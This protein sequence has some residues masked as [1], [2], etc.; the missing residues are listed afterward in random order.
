MATDVCGMHS[1]AG[2]PAVQIKSPTM[3]FILDGN[4]DI[5]AHVWRGDLGYLICL[6]HSFRWREVANLILLS[7][8][9]SSSFSHNRF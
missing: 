5:G 7:E 2:W 6:R 4:S 9:F 3:V 8:F 1:T